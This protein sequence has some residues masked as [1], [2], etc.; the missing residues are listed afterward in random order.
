MGLAAG[1]WTAT[2]TTTCSSPTGW[3]RRTPSTTSRLRDGRP[4]DPARGLLAEGDPQARLT[5]SDLSAPLGVGHSSLPMVGWGVEMLDFDADG[6]LDLALTN[7]STV[8]QTEDPKRLVPQA[9][10][11]LWN[12]RGE[13]FHDLAARV[14]ALAPRRVGRGLAVSDYDGDGDLDLLLVHLDGGVQL[15]RNDTPQGNAFQVRLRHRLPRGGFGRG[16]GATVVAWVGGVP[17]RRSATGVSYLSQSTRTLHF[18]LGAAE[19]AERIEVRWPD[20]EIATYGALDAGALWELTQGDEAPRRLHAFAS[21]ALSSTP[22]ARAALSRE[23]VQE[24]WAAHRAGMDALKRDRDCGK[25][26]E[27]FRRALELDPDHED[28]RYYLAHCLWAQDEAEEAL[29]ELD[30]MRRR[31]PMSLRAHRQ[32]AAFAASEASSA[33]ALDAAAA[34]AARAVEINGEDTGGLLLLGEIALLRGRLEE[35]GRQ[36]ALACRSNPRAVDGLFL[37][38]YVAWKR[39]DDARARELLAAARAARG[40]DWKPEG[41]TA[42]GDVT[43]RIQRE[44]TPLAHFWREWDGDDTD[45]AAAFAPLVDFL[46]ARAAA[47]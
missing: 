9:P 32:W 31:A 37:G 34:A 8:E 45:L 12:E 6:W 46:A 13:R 3:R 14:P 27:R 5:F 18:G 33:A 39:D 28:A 10:Q 15:L 21:P 22:P 40:E 7:G 11:L 24:F 35:A 25:A 43:V 16:D 19:R 38:A 26:V 23:Q 42:E 36:L 29:A 44:E 47:R 4:L 17:L 20:G 1:D 30:E 2:A 41:T